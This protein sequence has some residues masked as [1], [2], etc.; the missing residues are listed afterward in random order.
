MATK[1]TLVPASLVD[2]HTRKT[3]TEAYSHL[4][5][6]DNQIRSILES[7][8]PEDQKYGQ[9]KRILQMQTNMER[10][11]QERERVTRQP[12]APESD[13]LE[14]VP[15]LFEQQYEKPYG[16]AY[17]AKRKR[18]HSPELQHDETGSRYDVL[19]TDVDIE[20]LK[21]R[22]KPGAEP[23]VDAIVGHLGEEIDYN[24]VNKKEGLRIGRKRFGNARLE[25][26]LNNLADIGAYPS[27]A[28]R[29]LTQLLVQN[30][31]GE[32]IR[33]QMLRREYVETPKYTKRK[34][35]RHSFHNKSSLSRSSL[36]R[37]S[38]FGTPNA[39]STPQRGKGL[40]KKWKTLYS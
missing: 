1:Y 32:L 2:V 29:H 25:N 18:A 14:A 15:T 26:A 34:A 4:K 36:S 19:W 24:N 30:D 9:Y 31:D 23:L 35:A 3:Q 20:E 7:P 11:D 37:S 27:S 13:Y 28:G 22:V 17:P 10:F 40:L 38:L 16:R 5:N 39:R 33:N 21:Q 6:L 12:P 8:L